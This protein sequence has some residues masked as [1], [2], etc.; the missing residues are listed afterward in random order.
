MAESA[1][2]PYRVGV[3]G[4]GRQGT[5]H[6]R[7]YH[8]N[9]ST[10]LVAVADSDPQNLELFCRRFSCAG[11]ASYEDMLDKERIDISAPVLPV[12]A[13][14]DAVVASARAGVRAISCEKPLTASLED[15]DLMVEVC[16]SGDVLFAAGLVPR[17]YSQHWKAREMIEAGEIGSVRSIN[18]YDSNGQ[19]GCHG[20]NMALHFAGDAEVDWLVGT[21]GGDP[22]SDD[23]PGDASF[24][25]EAAGGIGGYIRF[26]N[27]IDCFNHRETTA[28]K[29]IEVL[30]TEGIFSSDF[31]TTFRLWKKDGSELR[32]VEGAFSSTSPRTNSDGSRKRDAE[33]WLVS[34]DGM[35][36][37][38]QALVNALDTGERPKLTTGDDLR[39]SLEICIALRESHRRDFATVRLPLEDRSL[40]P[41]PPK[42]TDGRR[43]GSGRGWV[44]ELQGRWPGVL[45]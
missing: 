33:G 45:G 25:Y 12:S 7:E 22:F 5:V 3:I 34:T 9:P 13:N 27:G 6:A 24:D 30:G 19:G 32:E 29:G 20:V 42:D 36:D 8:L 41:N 10:E 43:E 39:R 4:G 2:K 26:A 23:D 31:F 1:G 37:T 44:R 40:N 21:V 18:V 11:Y 35:R 15:A 28:K 17:N 16:R 14:A 38:V